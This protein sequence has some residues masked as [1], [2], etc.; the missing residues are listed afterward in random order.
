MD[1]RAPIPETR[2]WLSTG[3]RLLLL[4]GPGTTD[5]SDSP[6]LP[7]GYV[8]YLTLDLARISLGRSDERK[9]SWD[10]RAA[11]GHREGPETETET[12]RAIDG[13]LGKLLVLVKWTLARTNRR[14]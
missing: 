2:Q 10:Q 1:G 8:T 14:S 4:L 9:S 13:K 3:Q 11:G 6:Q 5:A 7:T 12:V